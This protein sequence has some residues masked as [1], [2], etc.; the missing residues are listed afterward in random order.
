[1]PA[2]TVTI[3]AEQNSGLTPLSTYV[4]TYVIDAN[5]QATATLVMLE[6]G[7][8]FGLGMDGLPDVPAGGGTG[9]Q[10]PVGPQGP[11]GATGIGMMGPTGPQGPSGMMGTTGATGPQGPQG[12][13]G[14]AGA[15]LTTAF[16][17]SL[18]QYRTISQVSGSH[19]AARVAGTYGFGFGTALA[20]TGVGTL[21]PL[22]L[23]RIDAADFPT[24]NGKTPK[25]R[26]KAS[27][28]TNDVAPTGQFTFGLHPVTRPSVSGAAALLINTIGA[29]VAG[30]NG[31]VF[32]APAA[33][34]SL[35]ASGSDFAIPADG[36]YVIG[37]VTTST[38]AVAAH[39]HCHAQLQ[40]RNT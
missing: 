28:Q 34:S 27:L 24:I 13:Q 36:W 15:D 22:A 39:V 3:G 29:A 6:A 35:T 30:S 38:V 7:K 37:L 26:I 16:N 31:A 21:A 14:V 20:I 40:A 11:A 4:Q 18:A 19:I 12:I 17:D 2:T 33:D 5:G 25:L 1:M 10:G 32:L 23:I 8:M 9:L